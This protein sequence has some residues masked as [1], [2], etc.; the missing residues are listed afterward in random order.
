MTQQK[1]ITSRAWGELL[2]LSL[3][4][5]GSFFSIAIAL[6][7]IGF[8][9]TVAHRV[10]WA[11]LLLWLVVWIKRQPIPRDA[12]IWGAFL[13]M[14][15]L[16]NVLPFSLMAWG[17]LHIES[18][19]TAILNAATA[20]FGALFAALFFADE[21]LTPRKL[22]GIGAGFAGVIL[23]IG[24]QAL[25]AFNLQSLGQLAV[26]A[27]TVSYACAAVWGRK[28]LSGLP[29]IVAAAGM[30]T[31]SSLIMIPLAIAVEGMPRFALA[32]QTFAAIGYFAIVATAFAY[33][34]YYRVL[35]MAGSANLML[36]T[37]LI[38]PTA[39]VLGALF[40]DEVLSPTTYA[41]FGL[42][43]LGL[44]IL[45]GRIFRRTKTISV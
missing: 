45:D 6:R 44:I 28:T 10:F 5:G 8:F 39:I 27:G 23:I 31:G 24:W 3:I 9:T 29:P 26:I 13:V 30:L 14:G 12:G 18:G 7:E 22:A 33:L 19:L 32:P 36:V 43:A 42:I 40:L 21:K 37:L 35:A 41:G 15:M 20:I 11:A 17:Q 34:L 1:Q 4:W 38:P 2:L 16:N 25:M